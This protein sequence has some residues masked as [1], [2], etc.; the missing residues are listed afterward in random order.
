MGGR[1]G[2]SIGDAEC[3]TATDK[4]IEVLIDDGGDH[5]RELWVPKSVVHD[6]SEVYAY[7]HKGKLV[8]AEWWAEEKE[9]L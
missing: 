6:D 8:V 4:A 7:G 1:D 9:L 5:W 3:I 2:V